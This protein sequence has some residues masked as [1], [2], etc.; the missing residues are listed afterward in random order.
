MPRQSKMVEWMLSAALFDR[1][2]ESVTFAAEAHIDL[3]TESLAEMNYTTKEVMTM[4]KF[5]AVIGEEERALPPVA[6]GATISSKKSPTPLTPKRSEEVFSGRPALLLLL[7]LPLLSL[8]LLP[9]L[10]LVL[11]Y[12]LIM[13]SRGIGRFNHRVL[14]CRLLIMPVYE[15]YLCLYLYC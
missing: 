10:V 15:E 11:H 9:L 2:V 6:S 3:T 5:T 8:L 4:V 12:V 13:C 7:L 14:N 1:G